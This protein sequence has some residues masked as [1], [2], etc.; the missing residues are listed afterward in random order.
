MRAVV[1]REAADCGLHVREAQ[2]PLSILH[3]C[4]CLFL[5]NARMGVVAAHELDGRPLVVPAA[6][7]RLADRVRALAH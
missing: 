7:Q 1:L 3:E 4:D 6:V 2:V 5:T